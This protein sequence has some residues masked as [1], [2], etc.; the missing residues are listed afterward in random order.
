MFFN[1]ALRN[2]ETLMNKMCGRRAQNRGFTL[3]LWLLP[4]IRYGNSFSELK[5]TISQRFGS[6]QL[7]AFIRG[8][9]S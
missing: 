5:R 3:L 4:G 8:L 2:Y 7:P 6:M 9:N 1:I